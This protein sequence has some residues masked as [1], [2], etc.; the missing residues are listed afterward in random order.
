MVITEVLL[1]LM[2]TYYYDQSAAHWFLAQQA[3]HGTPPPHPQ[4]AGHGLEDRGANVQPPA[5][6][7]QQLR[8]LEV[9]AGGSKAPY[10][11]P[12]ALMA[13]V[14]LGVC[15]VVWDVTVTISK[16]WLIDVGV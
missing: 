8:Q 16:R 2:F 6:Q 5:Q 12:P 11:P 1:P 15:G 7:A 14:Y 3:Q 9:D 4:G 13:L 10:V